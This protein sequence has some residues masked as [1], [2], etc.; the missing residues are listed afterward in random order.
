MPATNISRTQKVHYT[1]YSVTAGCRSIVTGLDCRKS[2]YTQGC[3]DIQIRLACPDRLGHRRDPRQ[4]RSCCPQPIVSP[5][6]CRNLPYFT[7]YLIAATSSCDGFQIGSQ[8]AQPQQSSTSLE[9]SLTRT[10]LNSP[11][12]TKYL[13]GLMSWAT[14]SR[15]VRVL[16]PSISKFQPAWLPFVLPTKQLLRLQESRL[17][18]SPPIR[19]ST[20]QQTSSLDKLSSLTV[21]VLRLVRSLSKSPKRRVR[22]PW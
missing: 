15:L 16:S 20:P 1:L 18:H 10:I 3:H 11:T 4:S 21:E 5:N 9:S 6:I 17:L 12:E 8:N 13:G 14:H 2:R 19:G 22:K 7:Y